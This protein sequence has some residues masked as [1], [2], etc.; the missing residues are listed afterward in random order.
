MQLTT[1][2]CD[3]CGGRVGENFID[4]VVSI[5]NNRGTKALLSRVHEPHSQL[6]GHFSS[7]LSQRFTCC[8]IVRVA[9][10]NSRYFI[11]RWPTGLR[12]AEAKRTFLASDLS[13]TPQ[14]GTDKQFVLPAHI[15][16][17]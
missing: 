7:R 10:E 15:G 16:L 12:E 9:D 14:S 3:D 1:P 17:P 5:S 4:H 8:A 11:G 2:H 13:E 6:R